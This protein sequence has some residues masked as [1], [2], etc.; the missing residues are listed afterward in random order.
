[1]KNLRCKTLALVLMFVLAFAVA[2]CGG[3]S[4]FSGTFVEEGWEDSGM[5]MVFN[6]N[7]TFSMVMSLDALGL[8]FYA[9]GE[10]SL[11]GRYTVD[12]DNETISLSINERAARDFTSSLLTAI[13]DGLQNDPDFTD[14]PSDVEFLEFMLEMLEEEFEDFA[15]EM[16]ADM[17][18]MEITFDGNFDRLYMDGT[19]LV[20]R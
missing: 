16:V 20:R 5:S 6:N 15:A 8:G 18:S 1:M 14:S 17:D 13:A 4:S 7:N 9:A 2:A 10:V 19:I 3:S 12:N 11:D